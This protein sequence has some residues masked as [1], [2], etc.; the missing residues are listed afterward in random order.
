MKLTE[1]QLKELVENIEG[2]NKL[3]EKMTSLDW[4][5]LNALINLPNAKDIIDRCPNQDYKTLAL[6]IMVSR[7]KK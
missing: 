6:A 5:N 7:Q 1:S 2:M 4:L 3:A